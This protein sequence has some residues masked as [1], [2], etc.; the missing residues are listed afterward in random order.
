MLSFYLQNSKK[1]V[2]YITYEEENILNA[3]YEKTQIPFIK[4]LW[5]NYYND[6]IFYVDELK[7]AYPELFTLS[8]TL[9]KKS[10]AS[11]EIDFVYKLIA[12][13]S[14]AMF[15]SENLCCYSD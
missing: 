14:F 3:L 12:I 5:E 8:T 15:H 10:T 2:A 4:N 11:D 7:N 6:P 13:I 9:I 1:N